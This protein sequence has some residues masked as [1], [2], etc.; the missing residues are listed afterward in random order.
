MLDPITLDLNPTQKPV[1]AL[2]DTAGLSP[3]ELPAAFVGNRKP[4]C[5]PP[6]ADAVRR[7]EAAM[8]ES[9]SCAADQSPCGSSPLSGILSAFPAGALNSVIADTP[10]TPVADTEGTTAAAPSQPAPQPQADPVADNPQVATTSAPS[11]PVPQPP[12]APVADNTQVATASPPSRPL[13]Q[14]PAAP[15]ADNDPQG[16]TAAAPSQPAPLAPATDGTTQRTM[17]AAPSQSA[18]LAPAAD[19]TVQGTT[20]SAPSRPASKAPADEDTADKQTVILQAAPVQVAAPDGLAAPAQVAS[21]V[22]AVAA[23]SAR[24]EAIVETVNQIVETVAA[25]IQV[26]PTLTR[27]EGKIRITLKPDVLDGSELHLAAKDGAL[28]INITPATPGAA[29]IIA[30]NLPRLEEALAAHIPAFSSFSVEVKR[31][32]TDETV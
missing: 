31:G 5:P 1:F 20:A 22:A 12:A 23:A 27:D 15:V 7:F 6:S 17:A 24:T 25:Q 21:E 13:P 10:S 30:Q 14:P 11:R 19:G 2:P 9:D 18:S 8:L 29:Q 28:A 4:D 3:L 16:A 32:K 26:S